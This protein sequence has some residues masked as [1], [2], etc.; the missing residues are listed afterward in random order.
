VES[1][2]AHDLVRWCIRYA[3]DERDEFWEVPGTGTQPYPWN[4]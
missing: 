2:Q 4:P 3:A 1:W